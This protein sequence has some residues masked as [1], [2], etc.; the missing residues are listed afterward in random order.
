MSDD[1]VSLPS[2]ESPVDLPSDGEDQQEIQVAA[3][4]ADVRPR[5]D[6]GNVP[7]DFMEVFSLPRIAPMWKGEVAQQALPSTS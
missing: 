3:L 6:R 2:N 7:V 5:H 4:P 1:A